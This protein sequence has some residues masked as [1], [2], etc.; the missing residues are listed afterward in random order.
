MTTHTRLLLV[1]TAA[2]AAIVSGS[3]VAAPRSAPSDKAPVTLYVTINDSFAIAIKNKAGK[4]VK[5]LKPGTY[6]VNVTDTSDI[7]NFHLSGPGFNKKTS[8]SGTVKN[9][10][11]TLKATKGTYKFICDPHA[12]VMKGAVTVA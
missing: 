10:K 2:A 5:R 1:L 3:A 11:W 4:P 9:Q 7:H 8:V 12:T 6:I